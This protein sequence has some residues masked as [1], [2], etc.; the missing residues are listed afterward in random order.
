MV[1]LCSDTPSA[2]QFLHQYLS[3]I[4]YFGGHQKYTI[5]I[6]SLFVTILKKK[7]NPLLDGAL[8]QCR[9]V[10]YLSGGG[11]RGERSC[12]WGVGVEWGNRWYAT[13]RGTSAATGGGGRGGVGADK[14]VWEGVLFPKVPAGMTRRRRWG[15]WGVGGGLAV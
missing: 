11:S 13:L 8:S 15:V 6:K 9:E 5:S 7:T 3:I 12:K 14:W 10:P 1:R 4:V 2:G